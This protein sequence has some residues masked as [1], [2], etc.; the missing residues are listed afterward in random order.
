[1]ISSR[2]QEIPMKLAIAMTLILNFA[3]ASVYAQ[4]NPVTMIFSGDAGPSAINLKQPD[5][6]NGEQNLS[7]NGTLGPFTF[8]LVRATAASPQPSSTCSNLYFPSVAGAGLFRF[9]D[10]SLL[11]VNLTQGGDCIDPVRMAAQCSMT[12]QIAGGTGRFQ[13]VT[14]GVLT[15]TETALPA[16]FDALGMPVLFT[17]TGDITGTINGIAMQVEPQDERR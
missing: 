3:M 15:Y 4:Q 8:R 7:G 13:G 1:M 5:T 14:G 10:G 11:K 6:N 2:K 9:Q 12:F 17:E 16:L